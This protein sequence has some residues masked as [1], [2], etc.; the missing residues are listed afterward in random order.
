VRLE[1][2]DLA[3]EMHLF[4]SQLAQYRAKQDPE[5]RGPDK[6][7]I[8]RSVQFLSNMI[9]KGLDV[10]RGPARQHLI[11]LTRHLIII[12]KVTYTK[13][14]QDFDFLDSCSKCVADK[15]LNYNDRIEVMSLIEFMIKGLGPLDE[16]DQDVTESYDKFFSHNLSAIQARV[17]VFVD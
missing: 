13:L 10:A 11:H 4:S 8:T 2:L 9:L 16:G 5:S 17:S 15:E 14:L 7:P 6:S 1:E 12:A 3:F